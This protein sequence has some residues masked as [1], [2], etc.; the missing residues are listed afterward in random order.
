MYNSDA[1]ARGNIILIFIARACEA[2]KLEI[3]AFSAAHARASWNTAGISILL[4]FFFDKFAVLRAAYVIS[5]RGILQ[6]VGGIHAPGCY[7][8]ERLGPQVS[9]FRRSFSHFS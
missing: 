9:S 4:F 3:A 2:E 8:R 1:R 6:N 5:S 7:A